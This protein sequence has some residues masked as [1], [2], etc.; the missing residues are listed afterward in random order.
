MFEYIT[1]Q[2]NEPC[3]VLKSGKPLT[4]AQFQWLLKLTLKKAGYNEREYSSHGLRSGGALWAQKSGV[5][6]GN[7]KTTR[8]LE[9]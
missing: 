2:D 5:P 8:R 9:K 4:Y 3:F 6:S 1:R 7:D